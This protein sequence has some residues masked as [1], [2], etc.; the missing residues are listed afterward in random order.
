M[1]RLWL[2]VLLLTGLV[3]SVGAE[4]ADDASERFA[5]V[6]EPMVEAINKGDVVGIGKDFDKTMEEYFPVQKRM[7]FFGQI[8]LTYGKIVKLGQPRIKD[9][10]QAVFVAECERG[11]LDITVVLDDKGKI[12]GLLFLQHKEDLPVP[13]K[14]ETKLGLPLKGRWLV[15]WG[16]DT[17]EV[18]M[19]H[20]VPNQKYAFDFVGVDEKGR[21]HKGDGTKNEDYFAFGREILSPADGVVTDVI[22]GVRDN[23]PGSMNP[24][25]AVGNIVFIEHRKYEVSMLAHLKLG[26]IKVKVGDKVKRG[27]LI[28]QCGNSG[29]SSESHL[30]YHMQNT[31]IIQD[32]TG[33]KCR[34]EK[35]AIVKDKERELKE[36]YSPVKGDIILAK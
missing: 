14:H 21:R 29:N 8:G 2:L 5:K 34:F 30:H 26:S 25:S 15:F 33:I 27:Q 32:G 36:K 11:K 1:K 23:K 6:V 16:G 3:V 13:E 31:P 17:K 7:A 18:N 35:V 4:V 24:Y 22:R 28:G 19:H 9:G 12:A 20:D 10:S